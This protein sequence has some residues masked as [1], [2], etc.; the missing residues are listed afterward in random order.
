M[1]SHGNMIFVGIKINT[2]LRESLDASL[3]SVRPFFENND[4]AY[5]QVLKLDNDEYIGKIIESGTSLEILSN[6]LLNVKTML[7]MICPTFIPA[8]GAI[9]IFALTAA[10]TSPQLA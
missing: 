9:K 7:K 4:P 10:P 6:L 2:K 8:D 3:P 1:Q 5:L